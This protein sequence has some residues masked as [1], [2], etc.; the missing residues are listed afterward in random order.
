[1][2]FRYEFHGGALSGKRLNRRNVEK[3]A[4]G[5]T[6]DNSYKRSQGVLCARAELD[7]QPT[8]DGYI[9]PMYDGVRHILIDGSMKYD[10][11]RF[12]R[13]KILQSF[14]ML[15]YET[16]EVYNMMCN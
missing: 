10:F 13:S 4:A 12:D 6:P 15:R 9:G 16:Q 5:Y 7:K 2:T 3:I 14:V 8:V 11:E 1:M